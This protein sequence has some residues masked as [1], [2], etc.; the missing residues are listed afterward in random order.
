VRIEVSVREDR[1]YL[2]GS[3]DLL[4]VIK[5]SALGCFAEFREH[6]RVKI[7]NGELLVDCKAAPR[8]HGWLANS[9][10]EYVG[11]LEGLSER[12]ETTVWPAEPKVEA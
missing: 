10:L 11:S 12:S 9:L 4:R 1:I 7:E 8:T 2:R 5:Q 3:R 6:G